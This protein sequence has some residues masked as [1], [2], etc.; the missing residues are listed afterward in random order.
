MTAL[1]LF[2]AAWREETAKSA[3]A[4]HGS[5]LALAY[6]AGC[7]VCAFK[8]FFFAHVI[9]LLS[10]LGVVIIAFGLILMVGK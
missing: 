9:F 4:R 3:S 8:L 7:G 1:H 10:F 2:I 5:Q 6:Y